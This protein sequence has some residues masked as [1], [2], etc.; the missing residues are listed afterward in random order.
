MVGSFFSAGEGRRQNKVAILGVAA[1]DR[2]GVKTPEYRAYSGVFATQP[3]E[4]QRRLKGEF[5]F[6][7]ALR[8]RGYQ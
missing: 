8:Q 5:I 7:R 3:G 2:Q 4:M 6:A 1:P